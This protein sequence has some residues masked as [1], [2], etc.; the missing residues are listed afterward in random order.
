MSTHPDPTAPT[1]G[2]PPTITPE[3]LA[4][5]GIRLGLPNL[6]MANVAAELAVTQAALYKRVAN[7]EALKRLVAE[8][9]FQRW[10]IPLASVDAPGG[11]EAYL[12]GFVESLCEVVKAHPGLPPYLLRRTVATA[13]MLEKIASHQAHVADVFG[14]PVDKV[15]WLL[16]TIAFYCI[17]GADT[18]Y[19]IAD[20]E[21]GQVITEFKQGMRALVIG[22]LQ[23]V[24]ADGAL[25]GRAMIDGS[26]R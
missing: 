13:S 17:A 26:S 21:E 22:S 2:R 12:M 20:D 19:A 3:R 11:L 15:R 10:Q 6:T 8:T 5:I 23:L 14:L 9:V 7:L 4:D 25:Q 1:R 18:I 16:A 24:E